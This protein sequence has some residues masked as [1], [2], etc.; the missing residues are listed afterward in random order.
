MDS[1]KVK[2][3]MVPL[4]EYAVVPETASLIDAV[5]ALDEAQKNL[6]RGKQ[7]YRAVLVADRNSKIIGKIGQLAFLKA[8]EPKFSVL[9]DMEKL[10]Q[11]NVSSELMSSMLEHYRFF[12][13]DLDDLCW[14]ATSLSVKDI[15]HPLSDSI[16]ENALLREAISRIVIQQE[17]SLL[18]SRG[19]D[20]VGLVRLS[21][22]FDEISLVMKDCL[23]KDD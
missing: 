5:K 7:P 10:V 19:S 16:D 17:L 12:Q 6:P 4:D 11:A 3:L 21:D 18:V 2:D 22:L 13:S 15:M 23:K 20:I 1:K 9:A 8:L 14:R